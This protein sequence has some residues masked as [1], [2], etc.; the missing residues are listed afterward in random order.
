MGNIQLAANLRY[1]RE[2]NKKKQKDMSEL[3]NISRQ[4]IS[5]YE[6]MNRTPDLDLLISIASHH[7]LTLDQLV[8]HNLANLSAT[9]QETMP[10]IKT[11]HKPSGHSLYLTDEELELLM[12]FRALS[13]ADRS[14]I[15]GFI[16][17]KK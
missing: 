2:L 15:K 4:A 14:I 3:F 5:N 7:D 17:S 9:S 1:L 10:Q 16:T 6:T 13:D 11:V 12:D 8:L